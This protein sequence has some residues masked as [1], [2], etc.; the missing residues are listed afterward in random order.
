MDKEM[1]ALEELRV[2]HAFYTKHYG[3]GL[4][5]INGD[6]IQL[7]PKGFKELVPTGTPLSVS[8]GLN[9]PMITAEVDGLKF[10]TLV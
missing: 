6:E 3:N 1:T 8:W 10:I 2:M 9:D 4:V 7:S 5:G